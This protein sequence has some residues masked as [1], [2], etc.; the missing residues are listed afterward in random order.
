M[1]IQLGILVVLLGLAQLTV[2]PAA[3]HTAVGQPEEI[4][5][6]FFEAWVSED[7]PRA[8][9]Y[10]VNPAGYER[11]L[12]SH[13]RTLLIKLGA[14]QQLG[15]VAT[16]QDRGRVVYY[17]PCQF[18]RGRARLGVTLTDAGKIDRALYGSLEIT[19]SYQP[20]AY[21][22]PAAWV[23]R[24]ITFGSGETALPG[25]L[26]LPK[27][28]N[29]K[30]PGIVLVQDFGL[31]DRDESVGPNKL[32]RDLAWG[33]ATQGIAVLR[34]DTRVLARRQRLSSPQATI[35]DVLAAL[36]FLRGIPEVDKR[37]VFL[38][39]HGFGGMLAPR[40]GSRDPQLAGLILLAGQT[41]AL[42]DALVAQLTYT[43][44]LDGTV[45]KAEQLKLDDYA[46]QAARVKDPLLPLDTPP[47]QL[48]NLPATYWLDLRG[49]QPAAVAQNLPQPFLILQGKRDFQVTPLDDFAA[50]QHALAARKN[51]SL[52]L[53][54]TLNHYFI[55]GIGP[56]TPAEYW[57][58]GHV[59]AQ[60]IN[61]ITC[62]VKER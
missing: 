1:R 62:W 57:Q 55:A 16:Y 32:F 14:F 13:W 44:E 18:A 53:Y 51:V 56:S 6:H 27:G 35:D 10:L 49:Y 21:V 17:A 46:R 25:A 7:Y 8:A 9:G 37:R 40:I 58:I 60:V 24:K 30:V 38:L 23:E 59:D 43:I 22:T 12:R 47:N 54:P 34:Y 26:T 2:F 15:G 42:E 19:V 5:R 31:E 4:A 41:R 61:D 52:K 11:Q 33:L 48:L 28:N 3:G 45:T 20:P 39:G 36:A 29:A 50:W